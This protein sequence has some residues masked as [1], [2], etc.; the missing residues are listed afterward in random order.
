M[1]YIV[2]IPVLN[3]EP[4]LEGGVDRLWDLGH[5]TILVNDGSDKVH[6]P[7]FQRPEKKCIIP[8][9]RENRG[10]GA[11]IRAALNYIKEEF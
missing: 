2:I 1:E 8:H 11:A 4:C 7:F 3:P 5:Q 6:F 10:K 9:H